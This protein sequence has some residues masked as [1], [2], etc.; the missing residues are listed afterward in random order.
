M[1]DPKA[2]TDLTS[3]RVKVE[4][5]VQG[6]GYRYFAMMEA[7][8]LGL[9]GWVRNVFDGSVEILVSGPNALVEEF[10]GCCMRGPTGARV[11]NIELHRADPPPRKGFS[12]I[13]TF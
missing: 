12:Q 13:S 4:G 1:S 5:F 11:A 10:V 7:R 3:L 6:V 9:D 8:R 2:E